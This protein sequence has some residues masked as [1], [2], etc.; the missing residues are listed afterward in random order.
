MRDYIKRS[1]YQ[2]IGSVD[3]AVGATLD[4]FYDPDSATRRTI[5]AIPL[6]LA[7]A[8]LTYMVRQSYSPTHNSKVKSVSPIKQEK[9][10]TPKRERG[11]RIRY[12]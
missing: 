3:H 10:E 8:C 12:A 9:K 11:P 5:R 1:F 2:G 6:A 4:Q 7:I